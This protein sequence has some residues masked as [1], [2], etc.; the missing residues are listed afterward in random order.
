MGARVRGHK[1]KHLVHLGV[2]G[3]SGACARA[4]QRCWDTLESL[5]WSAPFS[6]HFR[7]PF[8][9]PCGAKRRACW[10]PWYHQNPE[11]MKKVSLSDASGADVQFYSTFGLRWHPGA[12]QNQDL[13]LGILLSNAY[14]RCEVNHWFFC[15]LGPNMHPCWY[16]KS[17]KRQKKVIVRR[18]FKNNRFFMVFFVASGTFLGSTWL[19]VDA[20]D[21]VTRRPR[22]P[23]SRPGQRPRRSRHALGA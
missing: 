13:S 8:L 20:Q 5:T 11:K 10:P 19:Q 17:S 7:S 2:P 9:V 3:L 21:R 16:P 12:P 18:C 1:G 4:F 14:R 23:K 6:E 15:L 22:A